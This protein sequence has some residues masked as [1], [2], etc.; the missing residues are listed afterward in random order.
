MIVEIKCILSVLYVT[1]SFSGFQKNNNAAEL[2]E[3]IDIL[4][5]NVLP[6]FAS[7]ATTGNNAWGNI[8]DALNYFKE[9]GN[10]KLIRSVLFLV[11]LSFL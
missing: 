5:I 11:C 8:V 4:E 7:D 3:A 9:H 10:G 6:F 1:N 2:F